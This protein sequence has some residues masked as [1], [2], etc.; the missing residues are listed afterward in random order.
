MSKEK[1]K[2]HKKKWE[3][4]ATLWEGITEPGR[5]SRND[6]YNY[7]KLTK[8]ALKGKKSPKI[9]LLGSTPELRD[10]LLKYSIIQGAEVVCV[11]MTSDMYKAMSRLV[12]VKNPKEKFIHS[13][14]LDIPLKS[15]T[16][17]LILGDYVIGNL[18]VDH[19]N[20]FLNEVRRLLKSSG[21][22]ITRNSVIGSDFKINKI[23]ESL[24]K[25]TSKALRE[26]ISIKKAA[27]W[28]AEDMI[29]GSWFRN[30]EKIMSI[31]YFKDDIF[32][33]RNKVKN[34]SFEKIILDKFFDIWWPLR[35]KYWTAYLKEEDRRVVSNY[36][37]IIKTLYSNDYYTTEISPIYM[38]E[39]KK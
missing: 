5:P 8:L 37:K 13:N 6:I 2:N 4:I 1:F 26:E 34:N 20:N 36:F 33:L 14:W 38:L 19:Q 29:L 17:D 3:K 22:F 10:M 32:E 12:E 23:E 18:T 11:D 16:M 28:F 9:L 39:K 7:N 35:S 27:N 30:N 24:K 31:R 25:Y 21:F 15:G